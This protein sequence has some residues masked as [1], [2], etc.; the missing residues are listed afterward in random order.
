M[1]IFTYYM[2]AASA[3]SNPKKQRKHLKHDGELLSLWEKTWKT[4]GWNPIVLHSHEFPQHDDCYAPL[5]ERINTLPTI[6]PRDYENACYLRWLAM[7]QVACKRPGEVLW[8]SDYDVM[9]HGVSPFDPG[10]GLTI[11]DSEGTP[12]LVS[13]DA[14]AYRKLVNWI[15]E[16][17]GV[18]GDGVNDISYHRKQTD[19]LHVS[20]MTIF[21]RHQQAGQVATSPLSAPFKLLR[22]MRG[23]NPKIVHY[24]SGSAGSPLNKVALI[25]SEHR[26][27][28]RKWFENLF[29]RSTH[30]TSYAGS[31]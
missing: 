4:H 22:K 23:E 18:F 13:G 31:K 30:R 16:C 9:N 2:P 27:L 1:D 14:E 12:C 28:K 11:H 17:T 20:D 5:L 3:G 19:R 21:K 7:Y 26:E 8:M 25:T 6:N 10:S 29:R 15:L 24:S